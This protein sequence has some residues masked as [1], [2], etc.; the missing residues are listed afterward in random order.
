MNVREPSK[1]EE[2]QWGM[3]NQYEPIRGVLTDEDI[4]ATGSTDWWKDPNHPSV[5]GGDEI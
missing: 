1:E 5:M 4:D 3:F 2:A